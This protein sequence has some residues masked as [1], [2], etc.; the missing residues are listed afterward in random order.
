MIAQHKLSVSAL[1]VLIVTAILL[2]S[3]KA[4]S[5]GKIKQL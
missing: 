5:V 1:G 3:I 2:S 4:Q